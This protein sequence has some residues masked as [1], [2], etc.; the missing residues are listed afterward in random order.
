M[1]LLHALSALP[2]FFIMLVER[3]KAVFVCV[4]LSV[5]LFLGWMLIKPEESKPVA[6]PADVASAPVK[7]RRIVSFAKWLMS[8]E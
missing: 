3:P 7:D 8:R 4:V 6:K 2:D 5:V 1:D